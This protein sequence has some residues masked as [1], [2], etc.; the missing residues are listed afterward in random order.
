MDLIRETLSQLETLSIISHYAGFSKGMMGRLLPQLRRL[1]EGALPQTICGCDVLLY[2]SSI[3]K[4][5]YN[6]KLRLLLF[7]STPL[8]SDAVFIVY[9]EMIMLRMKLYEFTGGLCE[10]VVF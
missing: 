4:E 3:K 9:L 2:E 7:V 8:R 1:K 10:L 5:H 6:R